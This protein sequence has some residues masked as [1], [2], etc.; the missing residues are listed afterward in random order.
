MTKYQALFIYFVLFT[1][2][3]YAVDFPPNQQYADY[4]PQN[5]GKTGIIEMP[6]ARVMDDWRV[7]ANFNYGE[8]FIYYG[9]AIAP[10]PRLEMNFRMTQTQGVPG[11]GVED[12][13]GD[14]KDKAIDLK[15]LLVREDEFFPA[16]A[17]GLDDITGTALYTSK[18]IALSKR[19]GFLD[20]TGGYAI[21]RMGGSDISEF[22]NIRDGKN[23]SIQFL[24]S[25][26]LKGNFFAG[27]EAH[28]TPDIALKAEYS[29]IDYAQ[30]QVNA[31]NRGLVEAPAS[32]FNFGLTYNLTDKLNLSANFERGNS[33]SLGFRMLFPFDKEGLYPHEPDLKWRA[34][35]KVKDDF[36]HKN[37][38]EL[39][40]GLANEVAAERFANVDIA[41]HKNKVW[42]GIE[43]AKYNSDAKALGRAADVID[44]VAP[45][46]IDTLY[47]AL[48]YRGIEHTAI[49]IDRKEL[50][51]IK[52]DISNSEED[53]R[54]YVKIYSSPKTA[55]ENF[56]EGANVEKSEPIGSDT[57]TFIYRPHFQTFLNAKDNPFVYRL[58]WLLGYQWNPWDGAMIQHRF[59]VPIASTM[60]DIAD[61]TLEPETLATRT[62]VLKYQ[63]YEKVQMNDLSID[64]VIS[65]PFD[66]LGRASVGYFE[67]AYAGWVAE[68]YKPIFEG[69]Y[70]IG[71]EYQKVKK[72]EVDDFF[73]L[74]EQSFDARFLN[75][76]ADI[77]RDFGISASLKIGQFLAGDEGWKLTISRQYKDFVLGA[78]IAK[79]DTSIFSSQEN[80][81]YTDMGIFIS[82]P[83]SVVKNQNVKGSL[84]YGLSAWTRDVAQTVNQPISLVGTKMHNG[85]RLQNEIGNFKE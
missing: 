52:R 20:V 16:I 43:N 9:I 41:L 18:Y 51:D 40:D 48:K 13:Y 71:L 59:R 64:Q 68:W 42:V 54:H 44:E 7:R 76:Y 50:Q 63:Q 15:F 8:P 53:M 33:F 80:R 46:K 26:S 62:D 31:F 14:Y 25:T 47:L 3:S 4:T 65:L 28:L 66:S 6:N 38:K 67:A 10:F 77:S 39:I 37:D 19:I 60:G 70:G 22:Y 24:S 82:V 49:E 73:A 29:P 85:Y 61:K 58:T 72:R 81:D 27:V 83:L 78:Y 21:G 84:G 23:A 11:F 17:I 34:T 75:L 30:D 35:Q 56:S 12:G 36:S 1:C 32:N 45:E 2:L 5:S 74:K 57:F 79:T 69:R 55:F